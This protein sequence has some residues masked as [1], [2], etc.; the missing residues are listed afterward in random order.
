[1]GR[2]VAVLAVSETNGLSVSDQHHGLYDS[3]FFGPSPERRF[4]FLTFGSLS[5]PSTSLSTICAMVI[6]H[7]HLY[8][9][10]HGGR[11]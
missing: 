4:Y 8:A 9:E 5:S 1:V 3:P 6:L 10:Q 2:P 7:P 11:L